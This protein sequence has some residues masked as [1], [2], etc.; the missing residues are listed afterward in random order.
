VVA[1]C[2]WGVVIGVA[3]YETSHS[4]TRSTASSVIAI[5][6]AVALILAGASVPL[7]I[8]NA[9]RGSKPIQRRIRQNQVRQRYADHCGA[10]L[11]VARTLA[12][13]IL[14]GQRLETLTV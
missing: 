1:G 13:Q 4:E 10:G 6:G 2:A 3:E 7:A 5:A 12:A 14:T 11:R 9:W 8:R